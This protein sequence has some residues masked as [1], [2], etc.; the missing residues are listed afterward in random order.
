MLA[1]KTDPHE[2][3][4]SGARSPIVEAI[5]SEPPDIT[6]VSRGDTP[7]E[8]FKKSCAQDHW[9]SPVL[10]VPPNFGSDSLPPPSDTF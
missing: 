10:A 9:K 1:D 8:D 6:T 7:D 4:S 3:L 2:P 5:I